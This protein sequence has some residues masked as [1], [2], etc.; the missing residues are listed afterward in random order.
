MFNQPLK[1]SAPAMKPVN[2]A[3]YK[4]ESLATNA[5]KEVPF[6]EDDIVPKTGSVIPTLL[7]LAMKRIPGFGYGA[8]HGGHAPSTVKNAVTMGSHGNL[9]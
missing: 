2:P 5:A 6:K 9:K 1:I 3:G 7:R 4:P 8:V